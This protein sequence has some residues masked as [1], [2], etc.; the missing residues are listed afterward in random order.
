MIARE[1][2]F[3]DD[4]RR[5]NQFCSGYQKSKTTDF[6]QTDWQRAQIYDCKSTIDRWNTLLLFSE[7]GIKGWISFWDFWVPWPRDHHHHHRPAS[8]SFCGFSSRRHFLSPRDRIEEE[9]IR[10]FSR[11]VTLP[12]CSPTRVLRGRDNG[13]SWGRLT[14]EIRLAASDHNHHNS[15]KSRQQ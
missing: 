15:H 13:S 14:F 8:F 4:E 5:E 11:Y 10:H 3:D 7:T 9:R 2:A 6:Y 1:H 12:S